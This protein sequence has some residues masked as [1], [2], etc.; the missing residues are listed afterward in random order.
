MELNELAHYEL[1]DFMR[2]S[3]RK[4]IIQD[5][6]HDKQGRTVLYVTTA[7]DKPTAKHRA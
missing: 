3:L 6:G 7:R 2:E 5:I 4:G 1:N